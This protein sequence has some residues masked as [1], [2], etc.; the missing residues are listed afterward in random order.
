MSN[1]ELLIKGLESFKKKIIV[2]QKNTFLKS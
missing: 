2:K 1:E